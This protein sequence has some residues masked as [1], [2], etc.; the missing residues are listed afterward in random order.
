[1]VTQ[2]L[3]K[4][5]VGA[6][7]TPTPPPSPPFTPPPPHPPQP[8]AKNLLLFERG[9][10]CDPARGAVATR[11]SRHSSVPALSPIALHLR[12]FLTTVSLSLLNTRI[13]P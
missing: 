13:D 2:N 8:P 12:P 7:T 11:S 4:L 5:L 1:M 3:R 9:F 6:L 10:E